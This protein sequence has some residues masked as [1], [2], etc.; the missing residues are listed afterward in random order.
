MV[1]DLYLI[2]ECMEQHELEDCVLFL[3]L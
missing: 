1:E 3:P 2:A